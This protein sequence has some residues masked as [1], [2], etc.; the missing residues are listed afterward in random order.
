M[1]S[2]APEKSLLEQAK[3]EANELYLKV[4]RDLDGLRTAPLNEFGNRIDSL[5]DAVKLSQE[6]VRSSIDKSLKAC[7]ERINALENSLQSKEKQLKCVEGRLLSKQERISSLDKQLSV[8]TAERDDAKA[9]HDRIEAENDKA[10]L[11]LKRMSSGIKEA[12][13]GLK[14]AQRCVT[15]AQNQIGLLKQR[16]TDPPEGLHAVEQGAED[17]SSEPVA[18]R[19]YEAGLQADAEGAN[20]RASSTETKPHTLQSGLNRINKSMTDNASSVTERSTP[21]QPAS[22]SAASITRQDSSKE[23][24]NGV[25][26]AGNQQQPHELLSQP[27]HNQHMGE[28]DRRFCEEILRTVMED[29]RM[30]GDVRFFLASSGLAQP[31]NLST[32]NGKLEEGAY[33]SV[34]SFRKDFASMIERYRSMKGPRSML[35]DASDRLQGFFYETWF[36]LRFPASIHHLSATQDRGAGHSSSRGHKRKASTERPVMSEDTT[37]P[38][39]APSPSQISRDSTQATSTATGEDLNRALSQP[40]QAHIVS[41]QLAGTDSAVWNGK[42]TTTSY[43]DFHPPL[44]FHVVANAVTVAKSPKTFNGLWTNLIPNELCVQA[45]RTRPAVDDHFTELDF[46]ISKDMFILRLVPSSESD[47]RH[48]YRLYEDLFFRG[49]Y[50]QVKHSSVGR[51]N[52]GCVKSLHL[53]PVSASRGYPDCLFGLNRELLASQGSQREL[54]LVVGLDVGRPEAKLLKST[55]GRLISTLH[56]AEHTRT[57]VDARDRIV[58]HSLPVHHQNWRRISVAKDY[59]TL[60]DGLPVAQPESNLAPGCGQFL[61]LSYSNVDP[62]RPVKV[63]HTEL[64]SRVFVLGGIMS[65]TKLSGLV[66]VDLQHTDRPVWEICKRTD[67]N[68]LSDSMRLLRHK[69]PKSTNDWTWFH[70]SWND[71]RAGSL[72]NAE[73]LGLK[74]ERFGRSV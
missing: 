17:L 13:V 20:Q 56:N 10:Q 46:E 72:M 43:F 35:S 48:F 41:G 7:D 63:G 66:V 53:I 15:Y 61:K 59:M 3:F 58:H 16:N 54:L 73:N 24:T 33:I 29:E 45:R 60:L 26:M 6:S 14:E 49:R 31:L 11:E 70:M 12:E 30:E 36:A 44:Q 74:I 23:T 67:S 69:L 71:P 47:K 28:T 34:E 27:M 19:K 38:K 57:I 21:S 64:P 42:V 51:G 9:K 18:M 1:S 65:A 32:I 37:K 40:E 50:A 39:R 25:E 22:T 8:I 62:A 68:N 4:Q 55:W 2:Q 52:H 5:Q